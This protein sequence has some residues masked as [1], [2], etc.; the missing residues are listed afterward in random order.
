MAIQLFAYAKSKGYDVKL[1]ADTTAVAYTPFEF[2]VADWK[3]TYDTQDVYRPG[4]VS[5]RM[6]VVAPITQ[7][8][9]SQNLEGILQDGD[10][11]FYMTLSKNLGDHWKGY[12]VP[13]AGSVE[14]INGQ[15]FITLIAGDGFQLLNMASDGYTFTGVKP[16]TT[17]IADIFNRVE[18][19]RLFNGFLVSKDLTRVYNSSDLYDTL[20]LT[21]CKHDG[22]YNTDTTFYSFKEV[23]EGI[24]AAF[25]LR[26]YQDRGYIVFQDFTRPESTFNVYRTDGTYQTNIDY[27]A[28]QNMDVVS[29]GT[30]MYQPPLRITN[31][32][33]LL[34]NEPY[35]NIQTNYQETKHTVWL[36][37]FNYVV[38]NWA[39]LGTF[40]CD[41]VSHIDYDLDLRI[42]YTVPA[43][44]NDSVDWTIKV[45]FW[46][47]EYTTDGGTVWTKATTEYVEINQRQT[48]SG[49]PEP[50]PGSLLYSTNNQHLPTVPSIGEVSL[51]MT[52]EAS[53][54]GGELGDVQP[55]KAKW[56]IYQHG[57]TSPYRGFRADNSR[58]KLGED[59][60]YTTRIGDQN[61]TGFPKNQ[62]IVYVG[63]L[64]TAS[65]YPTQW[66][67]ALPDGTFNANTLLQITANR[68]AQRRSIPLE[69]Y[70]LDLHQT[71]AV[72][73]VGSWGGVEYFPVNIE[74]NYE[75][76]RVTY[77]KIVNLPLEADPL[78]YDT[79]L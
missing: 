48:I 3:V 59:V 28:S 40:F 60:T 13:S 69:Y 77:A 31:L 63:P 1:Y 22:V 72:T 39:D 53:Y 55:I 4:I 64:Q 25:G 68:I 27:T 54:T 70:E 26:M 20:F 37:P 21:G 51:G 17:Q 78:R 67:E 6:E 35:E 61:V 15:R 7:G 49:D 71:S 47:G 45:Y 56:E 8:E 32:Q 58:R 9:Y 11:T 36:D 44:Y 5:S 66:L 75:G 76:S 46:L 52:I 41:G 57:A 29:G 19:F 62:Q 16:F 65:T 50:T 38:N 18:M 30:K 23:L 74:Y 10:G 12:C 43:G 79:E 73:H 14:V 33:Y 2:T 42:L 24:C 34:P